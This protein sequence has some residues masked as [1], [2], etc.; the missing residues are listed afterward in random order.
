MAATDVAP[1]RLEAAK[2]AATSFI[3]A[4][5]SSVDIGVV[6]F[7]SDALQTSRPDADHSVADAAIARITGTGGTSLANA[8]LTCLSAITGKQ[9]TLPGANQGQPAPDLG[10]W[11]SATIVLFSDGEDFGGGG[12]GGA[13]GSGSADRL[14]AAAELAQNAGVHIETVG[15]GTTAGTT[16]KVD[17]YTMHTALNEDTLTGIAQTTGGSYHPATDSAQLDGIANGID[18]R[19]TTKHEDLPLAGG[20]S[21][22][23]VLLLAAGAALTVWRTGR[24]I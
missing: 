16:V 18:L 6:A 2:T 3:K 22:L 7:Q 13:G 8:I 4:Q 17:G 1:S 14:E 5:P 21:I 12:A 10:Y 20:F 9:V 19:L 23:A 24:L 11:G 15:V